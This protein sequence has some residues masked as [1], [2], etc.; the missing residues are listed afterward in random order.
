MAESNN[1]P[2]LQRCS[3][4]EYR[5][6]HS[7]R[8]RVDEL[9]DAENIMFLY[10]RLRKFG[11]AITGVVSVVPDL[12]N[13]SV[14]ITLL[15]LDMRPV[16][17]HMRG[18][19]RDGVWDPGNQLAYSIRGRRHQTYD[20]VLRPYSDGIDTALLLRESVSTSPTIGVPSPHLRAD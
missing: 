16:D 12:G 10:L 2:L 14:A 9:Q 15:N 20:G 8:V 4:E 3:L 18:P 11:E 6:A 17:I 19:M 7:R 1:G 13:V 5:D